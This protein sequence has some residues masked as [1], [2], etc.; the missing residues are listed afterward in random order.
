MSAVRSSSGSVPPGLVGVADDGKVPASADAVVIGGGIVG[1][2]AVWH[3]AQ[4]GLK[5]V[6]IDKGA[7][8]GEQSGRNWGWCR[9]TTRDPAEISLMFQSMRDWRD[10]QVFGAL[11]TG[12]RTTGIAYFTYPDTEAEQTRWLEQVRG[13]GLDSRMI[14]GRVPTTVSTLSFF[15]RV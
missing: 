12:F 4:R 13:A 11:D 3:L 8:G 10:P 6:L 9:N 5:A 1:V 14:S 7:I 15:I 2:S